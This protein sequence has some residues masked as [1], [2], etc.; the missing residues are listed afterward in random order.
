VTVTAAFDEGD[1]FCG[2]GETGRVEDADGASTFSAGR[3]EPVTGVVVVGSRAGAD[4]PDIE[5]GNFA[6]LIC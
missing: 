5:A 3:D 4:S 1:G 2:I 6:V